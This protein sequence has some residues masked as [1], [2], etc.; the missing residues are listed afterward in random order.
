MIEVLDLAIHGMHLSVVLFRRGVVVE[1]WQCLPHTRVPVVR[2]MGSRSSDFETTL[3]ETIRM[4]GHA[5]LELPSGKKEE[6]GRH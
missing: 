5:R 2:R 3:L 6:S 4:P 1:L